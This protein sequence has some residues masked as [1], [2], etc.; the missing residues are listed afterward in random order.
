MPAA[1][2]AIP[3]PEPEYVEDDD[4]PE[5]PRHA[6]FMYGCSTHRAWMTPNVGAPKPERNPCGCPVER[7]RMTA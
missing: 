1:K 4:A 5:A 7:V 2:R 3:E 6:P